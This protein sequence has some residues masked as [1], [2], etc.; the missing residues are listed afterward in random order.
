MLYR[1]HVLAA[2]A[3]LML[4]APASAAEPVKASLRLKWLPQAQFA[5]FY[6]AVQK[7]YYKAEGIDLTINPGGP[8]LLAENLV[9]T[10]PTRSAS[11]AGRTAS[12]PPVTRACPSSAS[13]SRIR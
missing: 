13:A 12:S 3:A 11:R 5:G 4:G 1:R 6:V 10:G 7:G 9:A 8:N 2:V